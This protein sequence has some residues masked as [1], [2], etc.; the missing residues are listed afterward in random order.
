MIAEACQT[1]KRNRE[2][3]LAAR[4]TD[5]LVNVLSNV[6]RSWLTLTI[7]FAN[8][9]W[10]RAGRHGFLRPDSC[11][12]PWIH[13]LRNSR[14]RIP[15]ASGT[16]LGHGQRLDEIVANEVEQRVNRA[17]IA[18]ASEMLVH[19]AA[20][21]LPIPALM[22][23]ILG[24]LVRSAQFVKCATGTAF[25]PRA[26]RS[27]LYDADASSGVPGSRRVRGKAELL[28]MR[29]CGDGCCYRYPEVMNAG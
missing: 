8:S 6:A 12:W 23:M 7:L 2:H 17:A 24:T 29:S 11:Q 14:P 27:P 16:D 9:L 5:N 15:S 4:A 1:L 28:L 26:L 20:G 10:S 19:I 18:N 3:Y 13:F 25:I 22:S 21:N